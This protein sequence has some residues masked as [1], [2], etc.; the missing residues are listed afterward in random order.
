M[1]EENA[2]LRALHISRL[3]FAQSLH[4]FCLWR[5]EFACLHVRT[6]Q[7]VKTRSC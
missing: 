4:N 7:K 5:S 1:P 6:S 2:I 3:V